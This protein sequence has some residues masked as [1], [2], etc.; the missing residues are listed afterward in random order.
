MIADRYCSCYGVGGSADDRNSVAVIVCHVDEG[1]SRIYGNASGEVPHGHRS[2]YGIGGCV[3]DRNSAW[4]VFASNVSPV[5]G[6][7]QR[8]SRIERN[9]TTYS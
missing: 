9:R 6:V 8:P 3:D 1:S 2:G 7:G 5:C 4:D